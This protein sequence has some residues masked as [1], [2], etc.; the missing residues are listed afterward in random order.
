MY[1]MQPPIRRGYIL[2]QT[3]KENPHKHKKQIAPP[4]QHTYISISLPKCQKKK[5]EKSQLQ[6]Q[7]MYPNPLALTANHARR[8]RGP[9]SWPTQPARTPDA[10]INRNLTEKKKKKVVSFFALGQN[11]TR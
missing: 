5:T 2:E 4:P 8:L 9:W 3:N 7:Y 10:A 11:R 1:S 6:L